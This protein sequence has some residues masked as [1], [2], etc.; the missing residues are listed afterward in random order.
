MRGCAC[1]AAPGGAPSGAARGDVAPWVQGSLLS[2]AVGPQQE[3]RTRQPAPLLLLL[4]G[5]SAQPE[6]GKRS[7]WEFEGQ[8]TA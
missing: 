5:G 4:L 7:P 6:D 1:G 2:G 8:Y 3:H